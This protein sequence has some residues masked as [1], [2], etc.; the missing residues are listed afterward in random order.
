MTPHVHVTK[1]VIIGTSSTWFLAAMVAVS[2]AIQTHHTN[3][4][5]GWR[6]VT[7]SHLVAE[8][9]QR[10]LIYSQWKHSRQI[11]KCM[12]G[13]QLQAVRLQVWYLDHDIN[14]L[15]AIITNRQ[16]LGVSH[17]AGDSIWRLT[18]ISRRNWRQSMCR[19]I[20]RISSSRRW[21]GSGIFRKEE[22]RDTSMKW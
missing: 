7:L 13:I 16:C 3:C 12:A 20:A 22:E 1:T 19:H 18:G 2:A 8:A 11:S 14:A 15:I 5:K 17:H 10:V 21:L 4:H 6:T 9:Y